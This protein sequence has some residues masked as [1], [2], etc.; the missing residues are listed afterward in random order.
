MVVKSNKPSKLTVFILYPI[1]A[2]AFLV[3]A[4]FMLMLANGYKPFI[5]NGRISLEKTGMIITNS[6]PQ[7]SG[8]Y[9]DGKYTGKKTSYPFLSV[10]FDNLK[11]GNHQLQIKKTGYKIWEKVVEVKAN[12]VSWSNYVLLFPE[13]LE[14]Q[15]KDE[16]SN[17]SLIGS[18]KNNRYHLLSRINTNKQTELYVYDAS[19][20]TRK[21]IW[22]TTKSPLEPWLAIPQVIKAEFSPDNQKLLLWLRKDKSQTV[23]VL[24]F[25][26]SEA[27]YT[28]QIDLATIPA[29]KIVWNPGSQSELIALVTNEVKAI[30]LGQKQKVTTSSREKRVIDFSIESDNNIYYVRENISGYTLMKMQADGS[31]KSV[32]SA[33][34]K[35][36][37]YNFSYSKQKDII[38]LLPKDT[39]KLTAYYHLSGQLNTL[40]LD[41]DIQDMRWS[42]D[43]IKIAYYNNQNAKVFDWDK[44]EESHV[45]I[46]TQIESL[47][48]YYDK[49][50]LT[51]KTK[52][53]N[54]IVSD[55][56]GSNQVTLATKIANYYIYNRSSVFYLTNSKNYFILSFNF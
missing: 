30:S 12:L 3:A 39:K 47:D 9:L 7:G 26:G 10:R 56:D 53:G 15:K 25:S 34:E 6:K 1:V 19:S 28:Y 20:Q 54:I 13:K 55:Y 37:S 2:V 23:A 24:D 27:S 32:I 11:P 43:G 52:S 50:H 22:P 18:S 4:A 33:V 51:F 42:R 41:Q 48:W 45:A 16:L 14:P 21:K 35:S 40:Q 46:G 17:L 31:N 29:T 49:Y 5:S 38:A 36:K 44:M 8:I